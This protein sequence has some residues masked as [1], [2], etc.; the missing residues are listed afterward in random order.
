MNDALKYYQLEGWNM[1]FTIEDYRRELF[2]RITPEQL[3]QWL[4]PEKLGA[5]FTPEQRIAG[6]PPETVLDQLSRDE[7]LKYLHRRDEER[8][9]KEATDDEPTA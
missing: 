2:D 7:I 1:P 8:N 5:A 6:L 9:S 4:S 3:A